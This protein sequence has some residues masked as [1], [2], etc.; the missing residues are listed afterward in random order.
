MAASKAFS[1]S[2]RSAKLL[3][4]IV[5]ETLTGNADGLKEYTLGAKGLERGD[6]F[7]PRIDPIVRAEASRLRTRLALYYGDEGKTDELVISLPK[8]S[9]VPVFE[10]RSSIVSA[11]APVVVVSNTPW[12]LAV[13]VL[14]AVA[15]AAGSL[16]W[17]VTR[18]VHRTLT[19]LGVEL[20]SSG[21]LR[22]NRW[23]RRG[24]LPG[25]NANC[26][27]RSG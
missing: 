3:R 15:L 16:A 17:H 4:F 19:R 13:V 5:E 20:R 23:S 6:A 26:V 11:T 14:A 8:G 27:R 2:A 25:W 18:P 7:D 10:D 12:K 1:S 9:Y 24:D 21:S 22:I